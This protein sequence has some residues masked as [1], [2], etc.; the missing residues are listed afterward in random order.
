MYHYDP[1][2]HE[3]SRKM[4]QIAFSKIYV[5]VLD[6]ISVERMDAGMDPSD[7]DLRGT[8]IIL[9]LKTGRRVTIAERFRQA[10]YI[11]FNDITLRYSSLATG[12]KLEIIG[13]NAQYMLYAIANKQMNG[14]LRWDLLYAARLLEV[15]EK[16][17]P[18]IISNVNGSSRFIAVPLNSLSSA[19]A[20][21]HSSEKR[22]AQ[23][24]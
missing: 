18:P 7:P 20:I 23:I 19:G 2:R 15:A 12:R 4:S 8:D 21:V 14:F 13:M 11:R 5:P 22:I 1:A 17:L 6:A 24:S 9:V 16:I 3:F 10:Q